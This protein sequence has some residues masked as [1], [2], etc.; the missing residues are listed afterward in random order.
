MSIDFKDYGNFFEDLF[1]YLSVN[2]L[3]V[4]RANSLKIY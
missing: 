2:F 3:D 1:I 4:N